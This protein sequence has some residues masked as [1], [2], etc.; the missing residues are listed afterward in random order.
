MTT[1]KAIVLESYYRNPQSQSTSLI[2]VSKQRSREAYYLGEVGFDFP[3]GTCNTRLLF[4]KTAEWRRT[5]EVY[6][7]T[8]HNTQDVLKTLFQE[9]DT[10]TRI[11]CPVVHDTKKT[12]NHSSLKEKITQDCNTWSHVWHCTW[13]RQ[14]IGGPPP[15][16]RWGKL[17]KR[18][19][20]R[21]TY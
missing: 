2:S 17:I 7:V 15:Q 18:C 16:A 5:M 20:K 13:P 14:F 21:C 19:F 11:A 10:W 8:H 12:E 6:P 3:N 9:Q 1:S 4:W